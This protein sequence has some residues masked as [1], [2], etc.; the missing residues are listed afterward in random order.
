[1]LRRVLLGLADTVSVALKQPNVARA[2]PGTATIY[3][4]IHGLLVSPTS[5]DIAELCEPIE[6]KVRH[7][8]RIFREFSPRSPDR[9]RASTDGRDRR[10]VVVI[11]V[12][13]DR[14]SS[15]LPMTPHLSALFA[16]D[17]AV[18]RNYA[19]REPLAGWANANRDQA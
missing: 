5:P 10:L 4:A 15:L 19:D 12:V 16:D 11:V 13:V 2:R 6:S 17:T 3:H 9:A 14:L 7:W 1:L 18:C 8:S